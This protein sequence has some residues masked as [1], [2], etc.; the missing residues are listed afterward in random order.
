MRLPYPMRIAVGLDVSSVKPG[1]AVVV[2]GH[3]RQFG[4]VRKSQIPF[5]CRIAQEVAERVM[6]CCTF[7]GGKHTIIPVVAIEVQRG[8]IPAFMRE[9]LKECYRMEGRILQMLGCN[10]PYHVPASREKKA[11]RRRRIELKYQSDLKKL[12]EWYATAPGPARRTKSLSS[13]P[14]DAIDAIA[15]ADAAWAKTLGERPR[16]YA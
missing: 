11:A 3:L 5:A 8:P 4:V 6:A 12:D 13:V 15:V 14:E 16:G 7:A 2:N 9:K 1:W 10:D